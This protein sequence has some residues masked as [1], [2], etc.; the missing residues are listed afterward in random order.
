M[1][2]LLALIT[3]AA[4]GDPRDHYDVLAYDLEFA[5]QPQT[6]TL[7]GRVT[8]HARVL[9]EELE[10]IQLDLVAAME[11]LECTDGEGR[12]LEWRHEEDTLACDL[13]RPV[14][15]DGELFV[16]VHYR[17]QP[18]ARRGGFSGFHW[19]ET[20][21]GRPWINTSCQGPG[22]HS[23]WP[24]KASYFNPDDKPEGTTT[25]L[26]VPAD[27]YGVTNG[28]LVDES[29]G[30]PDWFAPGGGRW[31]TYSWEHP[32]PLETYTVTLNV[33]PYVVV[34]RMLDLPG[35][36]KEVP[37]V[38][39]VLPENA[40]KAAVQFEQVPRM[41]EVFSEAFGP[42]PFPDSKFGLV[43]TNFWGMEH[44][45]AVAYGSSY[46]AWCQA[47]GERDPYARRNR[48]FDYILIHESAHEWWGNAVSA[49][50]WGH[51]WIHEGFGT[52]AEGVYVEFTQGRE[53]ADAYFRTQRNGA[54]LPEGRLWRG[55]DPESGDAY[56]GVIYSKGACVLDTLRHFVAD[57]EVWWKSLRDFNLAHRYG[58]ADTEDFR[59]VLEKNSE[60]SW[61]RFF[62]EWFYGKGVPITRGTLVARNGTVTVT[63][64]VEG[65]FHLPVDLAWSDGTGE[66]SRRV[67]L[68]PGDNTL[69]LECEGTPRDLRLE[70]LSRV[71]GRHKIEVESTSETEGDR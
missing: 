65:E 7:E 49:D 53:R 50:D 67:W 26:V 36:E 58:N 69:V 54:M 47:N 38:Y 51:F 39:Y 43:E 12:A 22:A 63:V 68:E 32:Y 59:A 34:E 27:L 8:V 71:L 23:W 62:A 13:T 4:A 52:Y 30:H 31:K 33:A 3:I 46:P 41:I 29:D 40:E 19:A 6:R 45:T 56:A 15:R 64:E 17:G 21:D 48:F 24:C 28:R 25:K 11:V 55:D 20:A 9:A 5:V 10:S 70:H 66:V 1:L 16:R 57:D 61:E 2:T 37:F 18:K 35:V 60:R 14:G 42:W 44:S